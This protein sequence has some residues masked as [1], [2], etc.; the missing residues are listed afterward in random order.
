ME[1]LHL[2]C[3]SIQYQTKYFFS[4]LIFFNKHFSNNEVDITMFARQKKNCMLC[5][6]MLYFPCRLSSLTEEGG[7]SNG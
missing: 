2:S 3:Y 4:A 7:V 5:R 1:C 6:I